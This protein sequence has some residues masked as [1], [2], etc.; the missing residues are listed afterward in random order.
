MFK[1][2]TVII[3]FLL[4]ISTGVFGNEIE[5]A[6]IS[7][8]SSEK[9]WAEFAEG[10]FNVAE[11]LSEKV[12]EDDSK[13]PLASTIKAFC[14]IRKRD[15]D[16]ASEFFSRAISRLEKIDEEKRVSYELIKKNRAKY[17][18]LEY[19]VR[20]QQSTVSPRYTSDNWDGDKKQWVRDQLTELGQPVTAF[21]YLVK[22]LSNIMLEKDAGIDL[23]KVVQLNPRFAVAYYYL[24][25]NSIMT[26]NYTQAGV[27]SRKAI[28]I[29]PNYSDA[30]SELGNSFAFGGN[31]EAAIESYTK[32]IQLD[33]E[34]EIAYYNRG[35]IYYDK[36]QFD[37]AIAD[38]T[39]TIEI[40]PN[41]VNAY[42]NRGLIY[43]HQKNQKDLALAD[44]NSAFKLNEKNS[45]IN[46]SLG[47]YYND[48]GKDYGDFST[49]RSFLENAVRV[50]PSG[51]GYLQLGFSYNRLGE[52]DKSLPTLNKA[53]EMLPNNADAYFQ[54]AIANRNTGNYDK[55]IA[56]YTKSIQLNP[57]SANAYFNRGL[58]YFEDVQKFDL[59]IA[60]FSKVIEMQPQN[61]DAFFYRANI[62]ES[63]SNQSLADADRKK[64]KDLKNI[65]L[66]DPNK[67]LRTLYPNAIFDPVLAKNA[68]S[69]GT[70]M[71]TGQ[72]C[73]YSGSKF[74]ARGAKI[75]LYP[76]TPYFET[77][78]KLREAKEDKITAVYLTKEAARYRLE[79]QA[80]EEGRFVFKNLKPGRYFIQTIFK[81][82]YRQ[83]ERIYSSSETTY[84]AGIP[85]TTNYYYDQDYIVDK[86]ARLE[87]FVEIKSDGEVVST[88]VAKGGGILRRGC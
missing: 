42:N 75:F 72:A 12:L 52:Y 16:K 41:F 46:Y 17:R 19:W 88:D 51:W 55:A 1:S 14:L 29:N 59:A 82:S 50:N 62:H 38:Y 21:D 65:A 81:F 35:N 79:T 11:T 53:V 8:G 44:F 49:A 6:P 61:W 4:I 70:S 20:Y 39:K 30:Y 22:G 10:R 24:A 5:E 32:A 64:L 58:M 26:K 63:M 9:A 43:Y 71:I 33:S 7:N 3:L 37:Q 40:N 34:N 47:V 36:K 69:E 78:H 25:K 13:E 77:W 18:M 60:D 80:N 57:K 66:K 56:D 2:F 85:T 74:D 86:N 83:T 23:L 48:K 68:L 28:E 73:A 87:K 76:V 15:Y 54:R 31:N 67:I 45:S 27:Y 84:N